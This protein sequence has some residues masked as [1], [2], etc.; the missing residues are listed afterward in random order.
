ME[1][2][3][4][5]RANLDNKK[6]I[7]LRIGFIVALAVSLLTFEWQTSEKSVSLNLNSKW[8]EID[9]L[10]PVNTRQQKLPPPPSA[11]KVVYTINIVDNP[12]AASDDFKPFDAGADDNSVIPERIKLPEETS[13]PKEDTIFRIVEKMPDFP[14][15]LPALYEYLGKNIVY[16]KM[17]SEVNIQGTVILGFVVEK[18]GSLSDIQVLRSPDQSLAAEA[19]RVVSAMPHWSPGLQ[20]TK[21]VRVSFYLPIRFTLQ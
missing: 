6:G 15:G 8:E 17:A 14:G 13:D 5:N 4:T 1:S 10:L 12:D 16:P 9:E 21:P 2:K 7:F 3:K 18:D 20:R 19:V 11:P